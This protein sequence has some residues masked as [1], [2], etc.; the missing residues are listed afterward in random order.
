ML[1]A[2]IEKKK[3]YKVDSF[4]A[5]TLYSDFLQQQERI[6]QRMIVTPISW[7]V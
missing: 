3:I 2:D 7:V 6:R 4:F 1:S 5:N